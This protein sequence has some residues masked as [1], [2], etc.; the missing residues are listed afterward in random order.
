MNS[1]VEKAVNLVAPNLGANGGVFSDAVLFL[2]SKCGR[3]KILRRSSSFAVRNA[4]VS[5]ARLSRARRVWPARLVMRVLFERELSNPHDSNGILV[6]LV[7]PT[8]LC[9]VYERTTT[10]IAISIDLC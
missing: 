2:C 8:G 6:K 10:H 9:G 5:Q 7:L 3:D 4:L 1:A